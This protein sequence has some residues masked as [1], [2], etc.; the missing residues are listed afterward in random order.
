MAVNETFREVTGVQLNNTELTVN[1]SFS[2]RQT[3]ENES[4]V[5]KMIAYI[6]KYE[7]PF[8]VKQTTELK[9]HNF[10]TRAIMPLEIQE[11]LLSV[12]ETGLNL[13]NK[14]FA[15]AERKKTSTQKIKQKQDKELGVAQK[16]LDIARVRGY[17]A[18]EVFTYDLVKT[19]YLFDED[20]LMKKPTKHEL[21]RELESNITAD[22]YIAPT[23]WT[24]ILTGYIVDVMAYARK[25]KTSSMSTFGDLCNQLLIMI[26]GIC[27]NASRIDSSIHT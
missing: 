22:D 9:L 7:N 8:E 27:K 19:S 21:V 13:Y 2:H 17:D 11:S 14:T 24:D 6:L 5:F 20:G 12:K 4:K 10:L 15:N 23:H 16:L 25:L 3:Q 1:H 26:L 18:Q